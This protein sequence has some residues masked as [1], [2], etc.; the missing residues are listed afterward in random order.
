MVVELSEQQLDEIISRYKHDGYVIIRGGLSDEEMAPLIAQWHRLRDPLREGD[1]VDGIKRDNLYVH[2]KLPSP[3]G[4]VMHHPLISTVANKL[5][6]PDIA[7]YMNRLNVKDQAL[8]EHVH[9]HQDLPYFNGGG[10]K[11]N[12]FIALQDTNINNGAMTFV[13]G[14]HRLGLVDRKTIDISKHPEFDAIVPSLRPGD[15]LISDILLW[16]SSVPNT[17][18]TD[19]VILQ[20]IVQ[21]ADDGSY[22]PHSVPEPHLITGQWRTDQFTPW[23]A[24]P[25]STGNQSSMS[26]EA[27]MGAATTSIR[28]VTSRSKLIARCK[29]AVPVV[30]KQHIRRVLST[31]KRKLGK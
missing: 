9:L 16:H 26:G 5:L 7:I 20:I 21:P 18:G 13:P 28:I 11:I 15:L 14:S 8:T 1:T 31:A 25:T 17:Q 24:A 27:A 6:G 4:D 19:R 12:F 10:N 30:V 22:Y 23:T 2:G 3:L 29:A